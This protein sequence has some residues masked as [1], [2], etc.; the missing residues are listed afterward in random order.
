MECLPDIKNDSLF[1]DIL[2]NSLR[3]GKQISFNVNMAA[4]IFSYEAIKQ[5]DK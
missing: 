5:R 1:S 3:E 4:A 2:V